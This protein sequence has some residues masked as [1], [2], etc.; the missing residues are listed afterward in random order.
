M[1]DDTYTMKGRGAGRIRMSEN[2]C[3]RFVNNKR[4][5]GWG[6]MYKVVLENSNTKNKIGE[7]V[8]P[9]LL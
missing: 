8:L 7:E 3:E 1:K 4:C 6:F 5:P 9:I 2:T